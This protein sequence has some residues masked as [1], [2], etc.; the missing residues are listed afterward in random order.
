MSAFRTSP[1][2]SATGAQAKT[3]PSTAGFQE[4]LPSSKQVGDAL[5]AVATVAL[6]ALYIVAI[7]VGASAESQQ[8]DPPLSFTPPPTLTRPAAS[9]VIRQQVV[10]PDRTR[11]ERTVTNADTGVRYVFDGDRVKGSDGS[12]YRVAGTT[13][14]SESGQAYQIVGEKF[15]YSSDGR[16]CTLITDKLYCK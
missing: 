14:F 11:I 4:F 12:R 6:I 9:E 16:S 10:V 8:A 5:Q 13:L 15:V 7:G 2:Q 3:A 1:P